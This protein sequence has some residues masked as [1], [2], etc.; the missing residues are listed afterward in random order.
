MAILS[1]I[2][3]HSIYVIA[4]SQH[5]IVSSYTPTYYDIAIAWIA[6]I[7]YLCIALFVVMI[8]WIAIRLAI[9]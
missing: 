3:E 7:A 6:C 8:V 5:V 4:D 2:P 9:N 1:T